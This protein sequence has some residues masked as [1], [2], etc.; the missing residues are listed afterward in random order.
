MSLLN[1]MVKDKTTV[2]LYIS[3]LCATTLRIDK[4]LL[5][6]INKIK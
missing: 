4:K 2:N 1:I 6:E 3:S 5:N